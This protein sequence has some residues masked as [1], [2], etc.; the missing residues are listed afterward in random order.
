MGTTKLTIANTLNI[1]IGRWPHGGGF[2]AYVAGEVL[3]EKRHRNE[4]VFGTEEQ[5]LVAARRAR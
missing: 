2:V 1:A 5:A 3:R 4:R